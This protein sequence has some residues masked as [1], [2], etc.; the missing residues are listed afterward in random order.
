M[1]RPAWSPAR[2][3]ALALL[4]SAPAAC[5]EA[6]RPVGD[7]AASRRPG[8]PLAPGSLRAAT[9]RL[10]AFGPRPAGAEG[11]R[12]AASYVGGRFLLG[13]LKPILT[14]TFRCPAANGAAA[15]ADRGSSGPAVCGSVVAFGHALPLA[16]AWSLMK[17]EAEAF[18]FD[19][20]PR[21][22]LEAAL[23]QAARDEGV[24]RLTPFD[25]FKRPSPLFPRA[26]VRCLLRRMVR[27]EA[28]DE[29][30]DPRARARVMAGLL[31]RL[32]RAHEAV[33]VT[34]PLDMRPAPGAGA[35]GAD[36]SASLSVLC[37][38]AEYVVCE[39][40]WPRRRTLLCA[41]LDG[42]WRGGA[43][44]RS[45]AGML[46]QADDG[47]A[48]GGAQDSPGSG[49]SEASRAAVRAGC[50][51]SRLSP[52][53]MARA[54]VDEDDPVLPHRARTATSEDDQLAALLGPSEAAARAPALAKALMARP[55]DP[56]LVAEAED[57]LVRLLRLEPYRVRLVVCLD[58]SSGGRRVA[59]HLAAGDGP[60]A[61]ALRPWL[62]ATVKHASDVGAALSKGLKPLPQTVSGRACA[63]LAGSDRPAVLLRT[64]DAP[65][66]HWFTAEDTPE[67]VD[68][69]ALADQARAVA[70]LLENILASEALPAADPL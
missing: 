33:L 34:A 53:A 4:L 12:R 2:A 35:H 5:A 60:A 45:L 15:P 3:V 63:A 44:A 29:A 32:A 36:E 8:G 64:A 47:V 56:A 61:T 18:T 67:R 70:T 50:G 57:V 16:D 55:D 6:G 65:R 37:A 22:D 58:L 30:D 26:V 24:A 9:M 51:S 69:A 62:S 46:G 21:P 13:G 54:K 25:V 40:S 28:G 14:D 11:H 49:G 17:G 59:V 66:R 1:L 19:R 27:R 39:S 52:S 68:F 43:G 38:V 10:M 42:H 7:A 48:R 41:A 23:A 31:R 20:P